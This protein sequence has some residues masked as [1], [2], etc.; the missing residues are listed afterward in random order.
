MK[1]IIEVAVKNACNI[2]CAGNTP[3]SENGITTITI[4]GVRNDLILLCYDFLLQN[5]TKLD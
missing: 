5:I 2:P 3:M 4:S 1:P